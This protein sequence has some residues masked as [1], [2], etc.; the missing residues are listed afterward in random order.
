MFIINELN[1]IVN[2]EII[3]FH[4]PGHKKGKIYEKLGY[5][6]VLE[7][8]Y[9]MD[10]TE[11]IG[12]D[13]LHSP[14]GI[15]KASQENTA[16]VFKSDYTYYLV[17]GS[18]C[19]IQSAIMSVC[20]P[21]SKII[22]N[23]DCHQSVI[24][25]CILGDVDIEYIPCEISKDTNILKG[26]N[27]IN[28]IDIID[29][30]LDAK[31]ILLTY[32]T[33]YGMTYDLEYICNYAHTKNMVVIVDEAHGAHL[34]LSERLPKT[35]LEQGADI[36]IQSTHKTLPSFTQSSMMHVKGERV[37]LDKIANMLR[38]TES[39]SPSYLLLSSLELAVDIYKNKGKELIEELLNNISIFKNNVN[40]N[41][42][43]YSTNDKTK[44]FISAKS[45]G[46]TGY[47]L[48][49][50]LRKKY[51]IQ[52][53]LSNYYGVLLICT[54]GSCTQDFI[55]LET[56]LNDIVVKEFKTTKLD[57]IKYPVDIPKKI[58][59][60]REAFYKIKKSVKIYDSIGK[61]CGESIVPYPPGINIIS[62]GE[63]I[64]KEII[65]YL[66]FC[67][68]KGMVISGLKDITLDFIEIIDLEYI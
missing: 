2:K 45:I 44:V 64:S 26:V 55:S 68:S 54:I 63:I 38:I 7:N 28:V 39:S 36:V 22:V 21:K 16:K 24:N 8:L 47:E 23:R 11:I 30:N 10:T 41:L 56:A 67:S 46:L 49:N 31:A 20:N 62:P 13:N 50:I 40:K 51:N 19:G 29:K 61:I 27:V 34:G 60:P 59:T 5:I 32:P 12:T 57:N 43:I 33:Y 25:G 48:E 15:I 53:E 9:K 66:K 18:S 1:E 65:D 52:V 3:S 4:M 58:L 42:E 35:A 17:N 6:N 37:D 14:E